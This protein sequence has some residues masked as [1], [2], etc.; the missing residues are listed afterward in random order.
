MA[1]SAPAWICVT[2]AKGGTGKTTVAINL[3][4]A[5]NARG[6]DVLLVDLDPQGNA[7]EGLGAADRYDAPPPT[8]FD[9][10]LAPDDIAIQ[11][12]L[13]EQSEMDLVPSSVE[14][15]QAE[16]E[17][18]L[19]TLIEEATA[20]E[21]AANPEA[22]AQLS[23]SADAA[24]QNDPPGVMALARAVE[25]IAPEYDYII[26]DA[27][28]FYGQLTDLGI[29][30]AGNVIV[31]ALTETTSVRAIELLIDQLT[32]LEGRLG[33][34]IT[35]VGVVANRVEST[36][37]DQKMLD[38]LETVFPDIPVWRVRKRVALQRAFAAGSSV[39]T[40]APDTDVTD[41]FDRIAADVEDHFETG[42]PADWQPAS[43]TTTAAPTIGDQTEHP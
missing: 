16:R 3:G 42:W 25:P 33:T 1:S 6:K 9:A 10:L 24:H 11:D 39:F 27:P 28:P 17:L 14:M 30:A 20:P 23:V 8:L 4:G 35:E 2:N 13:V 31:P 40:Y 32:A 5:L 41:A 7:T 18:T 36:N 12:L 43:E 15:L 38:W 29:A 26:V 22:I 19:A 34:P 37:E 21:T